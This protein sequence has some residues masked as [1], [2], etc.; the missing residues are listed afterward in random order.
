MLALI[1]TQEFYSQP[2][3]DNDMIK[4]LLSLVM[5]FFVAGFVQAQTTILDFEASATSTTFQYFGS[6]LDGTLNATVANPD[7]SGEN[8]SSTVANFIKPAVAETWAGAFSNPNP[9]TAVDLTTNTT[10]AIKVW[11]DHLGSLTL[12][13]ENSTDGGSNWVVTVPNTRVNEWETLIFDTTLP[14]IEAPNTAAAGYTY[15]TVT[16]FFD[17]GATGTGTDVLSFFDDVM[18]LP[19][20]P[21]VTTIL[22]FET[23]GTTTVFQYF[24]SSLDGTFTTV[25]ANPDP[26]GINTSSMVTQFIKPAVAEVWAGAFSNPAP[27][28]PVILEPGSQVCIK[29][30]MDHI[31]NLALKLEGGAAGQSNWINTVANTSINQWEELCFDVSAPS[32]EAPFEPATGTYNIITL[33]FDFGTGGSGT[34]VVYYFDDIVVK[35]TG[36]PQEHTV[37]FA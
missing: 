32:I 30:W 7:P 15:S 4:H 33:F 2:E 25:V 16:L 37:H 5:L 22:D 18:T 31:G 34:D 3:K 14:S 1:K 21:I 12:K 17:F 28:V 19:S 26:G 9:T 20:A 13:L 27:P 35:N 8:T 24:G 29:V 11:M 36:A 6:N 23:T 10:V